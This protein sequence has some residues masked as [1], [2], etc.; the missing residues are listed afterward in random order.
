VTR[1]PRTD[2]EHAQP[3]GMPKASIGGA[4]V[5]RRTFIAASAVGLAVPALAG[6]PRPNVETKRIVLIAGPRSH[7]YG[8]HEHPGGCR[9][10]ADLLGSLEGVEATA[11]VGWPKDRAILARADAIVVYADGDRSH[12]LNSHFE[13]VERLTR[14]GTGLGILHY[15]LIVDGDEPRRIL[16]DRIGG[17]YEPHWSVNP[18]WT[19]RFDRVR[20]HPITDGVAPFAL[21]DEW[22]Y[23]MRFRSGMTGVTPLL[24]ALPPAESLDRPDGAHSG[25]PHVREA[26]LQDKVPQHVAW[27]TEHEDGGR[28]FGFTG[29]HWHWNWAHDGFRRFL[30]NAACWLARIPLQA[31]GFASERPTLD[32]LVRIAGEPPVG[33][34]RRRTEER[35]RAW[36]H[37]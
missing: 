1:S 4:S 7:G 37:G 25:N 21:D 30:L 31:G 29:L 18:M 24:T 17:F 13:E 23:H 12:P 35:V 11:L 22:Y 14:N 26:V 10:M 33:W 28:G 3:S 9:L 36:Q 27:C 20:A 15:A 32:H 19:A 6:I 8:E 34:D 16:L 2:S 5:S